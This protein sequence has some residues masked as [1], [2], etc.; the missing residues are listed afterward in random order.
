MAIERAGLD[1]IVAQGIEAG[2]HRGIF[3][4]DVED[5]GLGTLALTRLLVRNTS[6]PIIA[7]GGIM[8]GAG[9]RAVLDLGGQAAQLGTAF[10]ACPESS[11]DAAYRAAVLHRPTGQTRLIRAI[12]G[13]P[14]RGFPNRLSELEDQA[15][16]APIPAYPYAYDAAKALNTAAK[17]RGS[18]DF[19]VHWAGQGVGLSRALPAAELVRM[20]Q[21]E[22]EK[23]KA[24]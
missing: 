1:A 12:S 9:L 4:P 2:G 21:Q 8:D 17:K 6:L 7:A 18:Q 15:I 20:L 5:E 24:T 23:T 22:L 16:G 14:A 13:R 10:I 19:A 11:A 3:S